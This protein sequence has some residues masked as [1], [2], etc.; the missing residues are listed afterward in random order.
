MSATDLLILPRIRVENAN[1][2]SSA[3]TIGFPAMTAWLGAS[4]ALQRALNAS[5]WEELSFT[6]VG[7]VSHEFHLQTYTNPKSGEGGEI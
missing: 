5:G 2:L 3:F 7:V 1:A 4:H 6:G